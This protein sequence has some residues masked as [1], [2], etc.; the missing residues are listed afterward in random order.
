[1]STKSELAMDRVNALVV[2]TMTGSDEA[3][4]I[5]VKEELR[6]VSEGIIEFAM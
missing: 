2:E 5:P 3:E 1:M 6:I 4:R